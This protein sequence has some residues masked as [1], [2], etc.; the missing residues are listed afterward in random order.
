VPYYAAK[1]Q[2]EQDVRASGLEHVVFRP[3][4]VFGRDGG[5]LPTFIRQVR[6]APV[7]TILGPGTQRLQPIW[8]DELAA[9]FAEA[10]GLP[11]AAGGTF[12]LGGPEQVSWNDLYRR[13]ARVLHKR[14]AFVNV[15]FDV[16]RVGARLTGWIPGAPLTVDQLTML[17]AGD[18]VVTTDEATGVF[19][20]TRVGLD[21]QIR[22]AA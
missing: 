20:P 16:A 21:A 22:R 9:R 7:V 8:I 13:I 17:E 5:V 1:W 14:R 18:N 10:V 12:E 11:Q 3:S 19:G 4:F 2:M 15:P 6:L